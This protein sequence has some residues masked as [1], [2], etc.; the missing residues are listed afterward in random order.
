MSTPPNGATGSG[1]TRLTH[2]AKMAETH[3]EYTEASITHTSGD[4]S[5]VS[6]CQ[7]PSVVN[8]FNGHSKVVYRDRK[9]A[10]IIR[11]IF[12][13][14]LSASNMSADVLRCFQTSDRAL[15]RIPDS[16]VILKA[17]DL[18]TEYILIS[19]H[20]LSLL[21]RDF[22]HHHWNIDPTNMQSEFYRVV[23]ATFEHKVT[24]G[25]VISFLRFSV[26]FAVYVHSCGMSQAVESIEAWTVEVIQEKLGAYFTEE[27][28]WVSVLC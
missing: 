26:A 3:A 14:L 27:N 4:R 13:K 25:L 9:T 15:L 10:H 17:S 19:E 24:W 2:P 5:S 28:G 11:R 23:D 18:T 8:G 7:H 20:T 21:V 6:K 22:R 1:P 16:S 12:F